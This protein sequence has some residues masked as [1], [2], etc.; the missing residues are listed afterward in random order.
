MVGI[1]AED[2]E[3]TE[4]LREAIEPMVSDLRKEVVRLRQEVRALRSE[5]DPERLLTKEEAA[6]LL[7]VSERTVDT[8][9]H[10]GE[11]ASLKVRRAR[12]IPH[13]ALRDYIRRCSRDG[14]PSDG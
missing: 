1:D 10:S 6:D 2:H 8:L 3:K 9:I 5:E 13:R 7:G 14:G 4:A 11:I 12:R